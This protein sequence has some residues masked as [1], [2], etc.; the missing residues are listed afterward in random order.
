MVSLDVDAISISLD[1]IE[2][3]PSGQIFTNR[4]SAWDNETDRSKMSMLLSGTD[5]GEGFV[6]SEDN[7]VNYEEFVPKQVVTTK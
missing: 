7:I 5:E 1:D 2:Y 4:S 3:I 6:L